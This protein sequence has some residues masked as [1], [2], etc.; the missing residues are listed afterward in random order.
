[1]YFFLGCHS[2]VFLGFLLFVVLGRKYLCIE[3]WNDSRRCL[4]S[5]EEKPERWAWGAL[6][7]TRGSDDDLLASYRMEKISNSCLHRKKKKSY[8]E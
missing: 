6:V 2:S 3:V 4:E 5:W 7:E 8:R 1:M